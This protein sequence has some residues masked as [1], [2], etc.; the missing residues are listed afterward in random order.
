MILRGDVLEVCQGLD[1]ASY[2]ACFCDP[3]YGLGETRSPQRFS[4]SMN[5]G[6]FMGMKWDAQVPGPETWA[7]ILRVLKPGAPLLAFGGTRTFHRLACAI[8]DAGFLLS[9]TLCWLHGQGFPKG[10]SQLKPAWEPIT[11]A[12]KPGNRTLN[13][14][15]CRIPSAPWHRGIGKTPKFNAIFAQDAWTKRHMADGANTHSVAGPQTSCS[16]RRAP[17]NWTRRAARLAIQRIGQSGVPP[18]ISAACS[19]K[20]ATAVSPISR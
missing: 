20:A 6:G 12:W 7:A 18:A 3:P 9:D 4:R 13:I 16:I 8:E 11:L 17:R 15:G 14:D 5:R 2:A 10:H 1:A 19:I